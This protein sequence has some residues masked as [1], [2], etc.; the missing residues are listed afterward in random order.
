MQTEGHLPRIKTRRAD[1][2]SYHPTTPGNCHL[3]HHMHHHLLRTFRSK[4]PINEFVQ[5]HHVYKFPKRPTM[6]IPFTKTKFVL[7]VRH[8]CYLCRL[9][10]VMRKRPLK[11]R[12]Q[13][14]VQRHLLLLRLTST[15]STPPCP[16]WKVHF[17]HLCRPFA[18]HLLSKT[19]VCRARAFL[20][21]PLL[22][23][24]LVHLQPAGCVIEKTRKAAFY[25]PHLCP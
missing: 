24:C 1:P 8:S 23:S 6:R 18:T 2:P 13:L 22:R 4:D 9:G 12:G 14:Q 15:R 20:P 3:L 5:F 7:S 11:T 16:R 25:H 19:Q 10:H 17:V 21:L